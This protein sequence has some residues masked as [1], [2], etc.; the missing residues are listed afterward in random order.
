MGFFVRGL[1]PFLALLSDTENVPNPTNT[2]LPPAFTSAEIV[3]SVASNA[4]F[5]STLLRPDCSAIALI[6]SDLFIRKRK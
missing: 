4:F 5:A 2:T 6:S 1:I 3:S